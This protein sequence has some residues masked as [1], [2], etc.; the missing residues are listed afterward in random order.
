MTINIQ[1]ITTHIRISGALPA[2]LHSHVFQMALCDS[3][4]TTA[5]HRLGVCLGSAGNSSSSRLNWSSRVFGRNFLVL[6]ISGQVY[7]KH[8][9][10][11]ASLDRTYCSSWCSASPIQPLKDVGR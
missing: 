8:K 2:L 6:A 9:I 3:Q 7:G 11:A 5:N 4:H 10:S 1:Q